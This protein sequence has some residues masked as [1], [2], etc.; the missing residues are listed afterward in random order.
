MT[1]LTRL[2]QLVANGPHPPPGETGAKSIIRQD[3]R[4]I[5]L[6]Y[7]RPDAERALEVRSAQGQHT[8]GY[9]V[10]STCNRRNNVP[11]CLGCKGPNIHVQKAVYCRRFL[12]AL[13]LLFRTV[14]QRDTTF[15]LLDCCSW[16]TKWSVTFRLVTLCC[17]TVSRVFI[18]CP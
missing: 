1:V 7:M 17:S 18:R 6:A 8:N 10:G 2:E 16:A 3:G 9:T 14:Q 12:I 15:L 4:R 5:N 11:T 13:C